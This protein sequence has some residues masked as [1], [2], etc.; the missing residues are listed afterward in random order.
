M[1]DRTDNQAQ[2]A[3]R[4]DYNRLKHD[5]AQ[6]AINQ[7]YHNNNIVSHDLQEYAYPFHYQSEN[8]HGKTYTHISFE[9]YSVFRDE[10]LPS[11]KQE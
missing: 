10:S 7:Q 6:E 9:R 5:R 4:V 3:Q 2:Q 11:C 8:N 1:K